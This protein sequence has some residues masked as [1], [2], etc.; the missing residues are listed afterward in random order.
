MG[1]FLRQR[2]ALVAAKQEA[3]VGQYTKNMAAYKTYIHQSESSGAFAGPRTSIAQTEGV[4]LAES[5]RL[6]GPVT[7]SGVLVYS[8]LWALGLHFA[9]RRWLC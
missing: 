7:H 1:R 3:L 4:G 9:S 8:A 2:R 5:W 6:A